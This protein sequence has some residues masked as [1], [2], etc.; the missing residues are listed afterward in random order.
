M[1]RTTLSNEVVRILR[2]TSREAPDEVKTFLLSEFAN[3]MKNSGYPEKFRKEIIKSGWEG[4]AKQVSR[5]ETGECPLYRPKGYRKEERSMDKQVKKRAWYKPYDSVLFCP[6]TP[7]GVL[8]SRLREITNE[9]N[10]RTDM[11]IKII[12]RV[13]TKITTQLK[14]TCNYEARCRSTTECMVHRNGGRGDCNRENVVYKGTCLTCEQ[15]GYSSKPNQ[16]GRVVPVTQRRNN[17]KSTYIGE[18][19]RSGFVRGAEHMDCLTN[20]RRTGSGS[21]AFVKH[22]ELYHRGEED[23]VQYKVDILKSFKKPM[24]RQLWEGVEIQTTDA[25]IKMNSKRDHYQ[26][27]VGRMVLTYDV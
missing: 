24:E 16:E 14:T 17:I 21:N 11:K 6:A 27:A 23:N 4:Y 9:V 2:N 19:S 5:H 1:K 20:P 18:T 26:T 10:S 13:G 12:E 22:S 7:D 15:S 25:D 8:A 3:R